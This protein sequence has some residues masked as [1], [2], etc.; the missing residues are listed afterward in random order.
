VA[1][2]VLDNWQEVLPQFI[3]VYPKEYRRVI[4]GA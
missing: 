4:E 3:K 1:K 2:Y